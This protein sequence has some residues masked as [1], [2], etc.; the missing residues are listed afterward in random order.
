MKTYSKKC[1]KCNVN[2]GI[3]DPYYIRYK[4]EIP[5]YYCTLNCYYNVYDATY[6]YTYSLSKTK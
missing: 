3:Y 5:L 6:E 2:I 4:L 1:C